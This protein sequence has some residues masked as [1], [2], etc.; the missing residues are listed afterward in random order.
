M[1]DIIINISLFFGVV[2]FGFSLPDVIRV[3]LRGINR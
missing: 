2:V 3:L 1:T